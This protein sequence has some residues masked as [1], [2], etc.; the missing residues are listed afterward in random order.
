MI[1]K[2]ISEEKKK[3][4]ETAGEYWMGD[5]EKREWKKKDTMKNDS[6]VSK[7]FS[8]VK[9]FTGCFKKFNI[10]WNVLGVL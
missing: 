3:R 7:I 4:N 6:D 2:R 1:K 10:M 8:F 9:T 5:K